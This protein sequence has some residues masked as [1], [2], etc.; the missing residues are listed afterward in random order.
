ML[1]HIQQHMLQ[2]MQQQVQ[3]E[4]NENRDFFKVKPFALNKLLNVKRMCVIIFI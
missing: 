2:Q 3:I 4:E 1:Q